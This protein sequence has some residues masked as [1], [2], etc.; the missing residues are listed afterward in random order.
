ML[1]E[2]ATPVRAAGSRRTIDVQSHLPELQQR[3]TQWIRSAACRGIFS[4]AVI[5]SGALLERIKRAGLTGFS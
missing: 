2:D 5:F 3:F 4:I 1:G